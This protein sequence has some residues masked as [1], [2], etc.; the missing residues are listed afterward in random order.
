M[1]SFFKSVLSLLITIYAILL[2]IYCREVSAGIVN[3]VYSCLNVMIPS[4]YAFMVISGFIVSSGL[5]RL[6]SIPFSR[7]SV[8]IFKM[9]CELFSVFLISSVAGYPVGAKMTGELYRSGRIDK[10]TAERLLGFCY[11]GGPAFFCGTAGSHIYSNAVIGMVIFLCIFISNAAAAIISGIKLSAPKNIRT[12]ANIELSLNDF[13]A[14]V[15][16]GGA[17]MLKICGAIIFFSTFISIADASGFLLNAASC[18]SY[19]SGTDIS[20][21]LCM[22]KSTIEISSISDM[23]ADISNLPIITALLSFGGLCV[24]TQAAGFIPKELSTHNFYLSRIIVV[25]LSYFCCKLV[26]SLIDI[27]TLIPVLSPQVGYRQIS[28]IPSVFLLIMTILLLSNNFIAKI[29]KM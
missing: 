19:V 13:L 22:L 1:K 21:C 24:I 27:N 15:Y 17:G 23:P 10:A 18:I 12:K 26:I 6:L 3:A 4:L 20:T 9:P 16:S 25:F 5:Y 29:K 28:P 2:I 8:H 14:S 11:M 7:I